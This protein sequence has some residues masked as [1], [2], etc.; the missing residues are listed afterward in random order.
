G[1][2]ALQLLLPERSRA[3]G[4]RWGEAARRPATEAGGDRRPVLARWHAADHSARVQR[5]GPVGGLP[6]RPRDT[7]LPELPTP[8]R[9]RPEFLAE[10][11]HADQRRLLPVP[12]RL[13]RSPGRPPPPPRRLAGQPLLQ[14]PHAAPGLFAAGHA[15]LPPDR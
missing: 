7:E 3:G 15:P 13:P 14:L 4:A 10:A 9:R 11:G 12:R 6:G 2:L 8:A 1:T 5:T